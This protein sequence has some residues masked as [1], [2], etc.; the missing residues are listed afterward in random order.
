[1]LPRRL[2]GAALLLPLSV[3]LPPAPAAPPAA[4]PPPDTYDVRFRF[5]IRTAP[6]QRLDQFEAML[7]NLKQLGFVPEADADEV[8]RDPAVEQLG[9]TVPSRTARQMLREPHV[10]TL[11]L[12]P[13]GYKFPAP[14]QR[15][16]LDI[17]LASGLPPEQ[18]RL[19]HE[20]SSN[21]LAVLGFHEAVGYDHRGFTRLVGTLP[22]GEVPSLLLDLRTL[23]T[24][25]VLPQLPSA[26]LPA[27][28]RNTLPI[29]V[30]EVRPGDPIPDPVRPF[31]PPAGAEHQL[32]ITPDLR[33][34]LAN[35][36]EAPFR[37]EA[38]IARPLADTEDGG[39]ALIASVPGVAVEGRFGPFVTAL[40]PAAAVDLIAQLPP[41]VAVR[42]PRSGQPG[43]PPFARPAG[44]DPTAAL[45]AT[46][47]DQMHG[48]GIRGQGVRL[49]VINGDF[50]GAVEQIGKGLPAR[51]RLIDLTAERNHDLRPNP[52]PGTGSGTRCALAAALA[53]PGAELVLIRIDPAATHQLL[54]VTRLIAGEAPLSDSLG[55]RAEEMLREADE[56]RQK[57]SELTARRRKLFEEF[58]S[59]ERP[60]GEDEL[61]EEERR[62]PPEQ[63]KQVTPRS[64]WEQRR[65]QLLREEEALA[66]AE[67]QLTLR[68]RRLEALRADLASLR[69]VGVVASPLVWNDGYPLDGLDAL[70]RYLQFPP[71][72]LPGRPRPMPLW[73]QAAGDSR[74][75]TW[76]GLFRDADNNGVLEFLLPGA[77]LK[78]DQWT[79]ELNFLRFAPFAGEPSADL[80]AGAKVRLTIQW[81]EPHDA[82]IGGPEES[83][84]RV[85]LAPMRLRV[86]QQLDP[87]GRTRP[88]DDLAL[89]AESS[90]LPQRLFDRPDYSVYE[91]M[92]DFTAPAAGRYALRVEG[93]YPGT[94]RPSFVASVPAQLRGWE[95]RVRLFAAV[96]DDANRGNGRV[97]FRDASECDPTTGL[98]GVGMPGGA[99]T[100]VTVGA[101]DPEG[102]PEPFS[103]VGAG[104]GLDLLVKPDVTAFDRLPL[105]DG[106]T[107]GTTVAAGFAAGIG[108]S[109]L[110]AHGP[111][112]HFGLFL[113]LPPAGP[114]A[115]PEVWLR[116]RAEMH[117]PR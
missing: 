41:V 18:Q 104:P 107:G 98:G 36:G 29:R 77:E 45:Q 20:Q 70:S 90:G 8:A 16:N 55:R 87:T 26:D 28:L 24:G 50:T 43:P 73:F 39:R 12:T 108:A 9:G 103:A 64:R 22:A 96:L 81:A 25:W 46:R 69:G 74:G 47:T 40:V 15:V 61:T 79:P 3:F 82:T 1:M 93:R 115:V 109:M 11:L 37:I 67:K 63:R 31:Q 88:A 114:I 83:A 68:L 19:L 80:P 99:R 58:T 94:L 33:E 42:L 48:L 97:L 72:L 53:A 106:P 117:R 62:L 100:A 110:S 102:R 56:Q 14:D 84:Y 75:Q 7:A 85:P 23:P 54:F 105:G 10:R 17:G 13:A 101:A 59:E 51:T 89:I 5:R 44:S 35:P 91:Q 95:L 113:R 32:K 111:Q 92:V 116:E 57:R 112:S 4:P 30:V 21:R 49:A 34:R 60:L 78:P 86:L 66:A 27:P 76:G 6:L 2:L 65:D 52:Q 38:I 71:D